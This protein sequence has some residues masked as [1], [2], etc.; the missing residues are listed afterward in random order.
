MSKSRKFVRVASGGALVISGPLVAAIETT[1]TASPASAT[2]FNVTNLYDDLST[3]S[4]RAA[5]AAANASPGADTIVFDPWLAGTISMGNNYVVISDAVTITGPG[6]GNVS[7]DAHG[8]FQILQ[9]SQFTGSLSI[10]GLTFTGG[11]NPGYIVGNGGALSAVNDG[12]VFLRDLVFDGNEATNG[13]AV[14]TG[15]QTQNVTILESTFNQNSADSGGALQIQSNGNVI[16]SSSTFT[17]NT[18]DQ[19]AG[20]LF[21]QTTG[22]ITLQNATVDGNVAANGS[23]GGGTLTGNNVYVMNSTISNNQTGPSLYAITGMKLR[24]YSFTAVSNTTVSGNF[25]TAEALTLAGGSGIEVDQST[26]TDNTNTMGPGYP[27]GIWFPYSQAITLSGSIVSGNSGGLDIGTS[28]GMLSVDHSI[29]G[30]FIP[31]TITDL[32]GSQLGVTDPD[33]APLADNGGPTKTHLPN[34]TSP[35]LDTGPDP[36]ATFPENQFDQRGVGYVRISNGRSDV[37]AVEVQSPP[38][39]PTTTTSVSETSTTM[40]PDPVV[41]TFTG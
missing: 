33:L 30:I 19:S 2:T 4:F 27:S 1:S 6:S 11:Y 36:V 23:F 21:V 35:A 41:P 20:A 14:F 26:I 38:D 7:L 10:S 13:G 15:G 34:P 22:N 5:V 31:G 17:N 32:G 3:G 39:P 37:G 25:G 28:G 40:E 8:N 29:I 12:D 9:T 16:I 18:A 24:A